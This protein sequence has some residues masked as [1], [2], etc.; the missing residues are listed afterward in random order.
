M[1]PADEILEARIRTRAYHLWE[2]DGRLHGRD[3]EFWERARELIAIDDHLAAG[4]LPNPSVHCGSL[5]R[6]QPIEPIEAVENQAEFPDRF[7]DQGDRQS[8]PR[9]RRRGT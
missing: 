6:D 5:E 2:Q 7:T 8:A 3:E 4:Q 9:R 1:K